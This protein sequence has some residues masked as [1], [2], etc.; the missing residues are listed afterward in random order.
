M[1]KRYPPGTKQFSP[2]DT[3][4]ED[5]ERRAASISRV[6]IDVPDAVVDAVRNASA[7]RGTTV[8]D[9]FEAILEEWL[10]SKGYLELVA[11]RPAC[12]HAP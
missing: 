12:L 2:W 5:L 6:Q 7:D 1:A 3:M 9:T 10:R 11:T 4:F 8:G